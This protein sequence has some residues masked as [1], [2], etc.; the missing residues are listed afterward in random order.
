MATTVPN[1]LLSLLTLHVI[2]Q[3]SI[4]RFPS[5]HLWLF[6]LYTIHP[7]VLVSTISVSMPIP[8]FNLCNSTVLRKEC[9]F[10]SAEMIT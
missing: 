1:P 3:L 7:S 2:F 10:L 8:L 9:L 6:Q 5:I 4:Y